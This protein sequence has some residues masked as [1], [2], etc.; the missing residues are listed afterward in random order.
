MLSPFV[1]IGTPMAGA[2]AITL[3]GPV[4]TSKRSPGSST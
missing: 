4:S 2:N 1:E 3:A